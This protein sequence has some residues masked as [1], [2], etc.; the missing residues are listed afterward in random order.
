MGPPWRKEEIFHL[1]ED[2]G[3]ILYLLEKGWYIQ[4]KK[5]L[6]LLVEKMIYWTSLEKRKSA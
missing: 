3:D 5:E 4:G 1:L 6:D 2:K